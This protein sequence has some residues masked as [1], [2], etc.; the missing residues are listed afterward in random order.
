MM[1]TNK[2]YI[3]LLGAL[4][5][6]ASCAKEAAQPTPSAPVTLKAVIADET[7]A[8]LDDGTGAFAFS[9]TDEIILSNGSGVYTSDHTELSQDGSTA[10]FTMSAGFEKTG[11]G[12][13]AYPASSVSEITASS[14]T[15]TLPTSYTYEEVGG[16]DRSASQVPCPMIASFNA[17]NDQMVFKQAG[18]VIRF[19]IKNCLEGTL[20][21]TFKSQVT[22]T[23]TLTAEPKDNIGIHADNFQN[24]NGG[25]SI[26]VTGVPAVTG[27]QAFYVNLPVPIG[28]DPINVTVWNEG[29]GESGGKFKNLS[30]N[31][32][33]LARAD[34][35]KRGV[36]LEERLS[37]TTFGG[38]KIAGFLY[39]HDEHSDNPIYY[40]V[41][42]DP[43]ELLKHY[44]QVYNDKQYYFSWNDIINNIPNLFTAKGITIEGQQYDVPTGGEYGQWK[45]IV[46]LDRPK[47]S[48][49]SVNANYAFV[50]VTGIKAES[51]LY[52]E[53]IRGL[54]LFPDSEVIELPSGASL[55]VFD[56]AINANA[57]SLTVGALRLLEKKG[58]IF[59]PTAGYSDGKYDTWSDLNKGGYFWSRTN[60]SASYAYA[61]AITYDS[62]YSLAPI[63]SE[64]AID[65]KATAYFP[66][67]LLKL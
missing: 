7:K 28:T 18:S 29:E 13:A 20:T 65:L 38:F 46:G 1:K 21:F 61:L 22:G 40:G 43:L 39:N 34:G 42:T 53:T 49:G 27:T 52:P 67:L 33:S 9:S 16:T 4:T 47:A 36:N 35:Y 57:N 12:F 11:A 48:I 30:G 25:Y 54:L 24:K 50:T 8:T 15:F 17:S 37:A 2:S 14:V 5:L 64:T 26:Q 10:T 32:V 44:G 63:N 6:A 41:L 51:A 58:C 19:R 55:T 59:L 60:Y 31:P 3:L 62:S 23:V 45:T 66:I 56:T